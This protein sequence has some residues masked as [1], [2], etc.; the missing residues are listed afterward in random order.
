MS[1]KI[2]ESQRRKIKKEVAKRRKFMEWSWNVGKDLNSIEAI[3]DVLRLEDSRSN[4]GLY[5]GPGLNPYSGR[6]LIYA[7][8]DSCTR[9]RH[10]VG[11]LD[12]QLDIKLPTGLSIAENMR[13]RGMAERK[14]A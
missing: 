3:F 8:I 9:V 1:K 13:I 6:Y 11:E 4:N 12:H 10:L 7:G 5:R 14:A 2:T